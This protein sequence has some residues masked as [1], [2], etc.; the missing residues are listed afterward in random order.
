MHNVLEKLT[1]GASVLNV[2]VLSALNE[3]EV[4]LDKDTE[5]WMKNELTSGTG[6]ETRSTAGARTASRRGSAPPSSWS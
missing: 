5:S 4:K 2:N 1:H 6:S 3:G